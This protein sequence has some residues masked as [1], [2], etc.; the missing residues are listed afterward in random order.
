[1]ILSEAELNVSITKLI[2]NIELS[3]SQHVHIGQTP[4]QG[5]SVRGRLSYQAQMMQNQYP[6]ANK[7]LKQKFFRLGSKTLLNIFR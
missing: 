5:Q 4:H 3:A 7:S 6:L 1:M 2:L